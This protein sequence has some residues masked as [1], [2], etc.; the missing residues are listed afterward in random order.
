MTTEGEGDNVEETGNNHFLFNL[1]RYAKE[2]CSNADFFVIVRTTRKRHSTSFNI[3]ESSDDE[4]YELSEDGSSEDEWRYTRKKST[5]RKLKPRPARTLKKSLAENAKRLKTEFNETIR[6]TSPGVLSSEETNSDAP[7]PDTTTIETTKSLETEENKP[8]V[9][10]MCDV[11]DKVAILEETNEI[12]YSLIRSSSSIRSPDGALMKCD[13]SIKTEQLDTKIKKENVDAV[14]KVENT[15]VKNVKPDKDQETD[16]DTVIILSDDDD[17]VPGDSN[18]VVLNCNILQTY[19]SPIL[20]GNETTTTSPATPTIRVRPLEQ[21]S[22]S[23]TPGFDGTASPTITQGITPGIPFSTVPQNMPSIPFPSPVGSHAPTTNSP[24]F[25][26]P[27]IAP[28]RMRGTRGSPRSSRQSS[29]G[30]VRT[31]NASP[32]T[33][34]SPDV[35]CLTPRSTSRRR[36]TSNYSPR[37]RFSTPPRL[38][39]ISLNDISPSGTVIRNGLDSITITPTKKSPERPPVQRRLFKS[40]VEGIITARETGY[41]VSLANGRFFPLSQVQVEKLR[42]QNNGALPT[43]LRIPVPSDVAASIETRIVIED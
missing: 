12:D 34:A 2:R 36:P 3:L 15:T 22:N 23:P 4:N 11:I 25:S 26:A 17:E 7:K 41:V 16:A 33:R 6:P 9:T 14:V 29:R 42:E 21:I 1:N 5:Q 27:V 30:R 35:R 13:S 10:F 43:K 8:V 18:T 24:D 19:A 31:P 38:D 37:S 20:T 32:R 28:P 39:S 40:E